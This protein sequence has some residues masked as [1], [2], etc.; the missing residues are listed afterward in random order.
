MLALVAG[1]STAACGDDPTTTRPPLGVR[2]TVKP[3]VLT[4]SVGETA[5][6]EATVQ[7]A[8]GRALTNSEIKWSSSAPAVVAVSA[9]GT[10]TA[11]TEGMATVGAYAEQTVEFARVVVQAGFR[12]PLSRWRVVTE[13][14]GLAPG[15]SGG[16]GGLIEDGTYDCSHA[17]ISRYSLDFVAVSERPS[18]S[19]PGSGGVFAAA[20][21]IITDICLQP[22]PQVTC[23]PNGPYVQVEHAGGFLSLYAHL[24]PGS[25][26]LRRKT[27]VRQGQMLGSLG[28]FGV[29]TV[30]WLHFEMRH[31]NR[32]SGAASVLNVVDLGGRSFL[33][34]RVGDSSGE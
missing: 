26:S 2:I 16:E 31:E 23:G 5:S 7:D 8:Q 12:V 1:L 28:A 24:D 3:A 14:G 34:Y 21:G 4:L 11:L 13:M 10:V 25:V 9:T 32:G 6:L 18:P 20:D 17:G 27:P 22:I 33:D 19:A 30:P 29:D 15:C